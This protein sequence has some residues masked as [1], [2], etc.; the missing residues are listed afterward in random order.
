MYAHAARRIKSEQVQKLD[1][2]TLHV[3][4]SGGEP[5]SAAT[6]RSFASMLAPGGLKLGACYPCLGMAENGATLLCPFTLA[7]C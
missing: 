7:S 5:V 4:M 3:Y 2:S 6:V 1:L